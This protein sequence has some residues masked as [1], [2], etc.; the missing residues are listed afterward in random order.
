MKYYYSISEVAEK[1]NVKSYVLR[2][3]EQEFKELRP[4]KTKGGRRLYTTKDINLISIIKKLLYEEHY[5]IE[6]VR[7][8]LKNCGGKRCDDF[9][10]LTRPTDK[11]DKGVLKEIE[12]GLKDLL[13]ILN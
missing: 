3:W 10:S 12:K 7:E 4:K 9:E 5:T 13:N 11:V 1:T 8:K 2:Y 6:G